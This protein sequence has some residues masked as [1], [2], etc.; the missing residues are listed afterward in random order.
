[1]G[2]SSLKKGD[3]EGYEIDISINALFHTNKNRM[4]HYIYVN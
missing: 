1:M 3:D 4:N 2:K